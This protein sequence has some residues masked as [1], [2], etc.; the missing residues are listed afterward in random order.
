MLALNAA[1]EAARASEQGRGFAVVATEV[2]SLAGRSA[3]AAKE[4]K[5]LIQDSVVRVGEGSKLVD[6]SGGTLAEIV[7][8]VK[9]A[10][11]IVSRIADASREQSQ[12]IEQVNRAVT[13]MDEMTQQNAALVE[14]AAAASQSI[15]EQ[16]QALNSM[17]ARY[18]VGGETQ[19]S[20]SG[21][22]PA[23]A[24]RA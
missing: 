3:A 21:Y 14:Q 5:A 6:E 4:I 8:A 1:V 22:A 10:T 15:V 9:S 12:G 7:A 20:A 19:P 2:R 24:R 11:D 23:L 13:Q 17:V 18:H 16:I